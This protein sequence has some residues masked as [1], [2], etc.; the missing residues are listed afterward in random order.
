[1]IREHVFMAKVAERIADA[2]HEI[3]RLANAQVY[4]CREKQTLT[5]MDF[6]LECD[7]STLDDIVD[8]LKMYGVFPEA[9]TVG[10]TNHVIHVT[11]VPSK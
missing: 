3:E 10:S 11:I 9:I 6:A 4:G 8:Y 1:M 5:R 2:V 7:R